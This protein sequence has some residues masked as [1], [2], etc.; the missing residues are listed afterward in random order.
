MW[1]RRVVA[2][3][4]YVLLLQYA[5]VNYVAPDFWYL[6]FRS[7]TPDLTSYVIALIL[8]GGLSTMLPARLTRASDFMLWV[9]FTLT[10]AP[11]MTAAYYADIL[12]RDELVRFTWTIAGCFAMAVILIGNGPRFTIRLRLPWTV[13]WV[14]VG[15]LSATTYGYLAITTGL[16]IQYMAL[17]D[18][19]DSRLQYRAVVTAAGAFLGYLVAAQAYVINPLFMASGILRR[20]IG[21]LGLGAMGQ[22]IIFSI[23]GYKIAILSVPAA[24][25][26]A[27]VFRYRR[28]IRGETTLNGILGVAAGS[29]ALDGIFGGGGLTLIL[30]NRFLLIPATLTSAYV[31]VF[32]PMEKAKW[33]YSFLSGITDYPYQLAPNFLVGAVFSGSPVV[34]ANANFLADG[35]ANYGYAGMLIETLAFVLLCWLL[36]ATLR[37]IPMPVVCVVLLLPAIALANVSVFTAITT[38]GFALIMMLGVIVP[39]NG[40]A[41]TR[42]SARGRRSSRQGITL[43]SG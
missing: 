4:V 22:V 19:T 3:I 23:T 29:L 13:T 35:Y 34:S 38:Q 26:I 24:I 10:I 40:W 20:Q 25:G 12:P 1:A 36:D 33:G 2:T 31:K 21:V 42:S 18:V 30:V 16:R 17:S 39:R 32:E 43:P 14:A 5:Y 28:R 41:R 37:Q 15:I 6:G 8:V 27:L 11:S 9:T 7:R